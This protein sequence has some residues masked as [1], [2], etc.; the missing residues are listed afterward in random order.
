MNA[1]YLRTVPE[2]VADAVA[3]HGAQWRGSAIVAL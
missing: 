2:A 3:E 1:G